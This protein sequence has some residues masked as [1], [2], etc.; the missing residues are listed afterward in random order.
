MSAE[1]L[2]GMPGQPGGPPSFDAALELFRAGDYRGALAAFQ[3]FRTQYPDSPY[4]RSAILKFDL[5]FDHLAG[6][7]MEIGRFYQR[8]GQWL[9]SVMR[10]RQVT[11]HPG[12]AQGFGRL[13]RD[14]I[15]VIC[16]PGEPVAALVAV[17]RLPP[18]A[19]VADAESRLL[20]SRLV[21]LSGTLVEGGQPA[22]GVGK[23]VGYRPLCSKGLDLNVGQRL[24][25]GHGVPLDA[26]L[27]DLLGALRRVYS[28][29]MARR[30]HS[31]RVRP[32]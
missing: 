16:I 3:S 20:A 8:R 12:P 15:P 11:M 17:R 5:A 1:S 7:E 28:R 31:E 14:E 18:D 4:A 24:G 19:T 13:G 29:R 26:L 27:W 6:K 2:P 25:V 9:A 32:S 22:R 30:T 23:H 10:F 21:P